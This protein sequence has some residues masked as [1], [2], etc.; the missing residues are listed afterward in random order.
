ME[1]CDEC[2]S[3][4]A[5]K[6]INGKVVMACPK[7]GAGKELSKGEQKHTLRFWGTH[8]NCLH[9]DGVALAVWVSFVYFSKSLSS[10]N[11]PCVEIPPC[12]KRSV[13]PLRF[14][15][16]RNQQVQVLQVNSRI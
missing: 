2:S 4:L 11:A 5:P 15:K 1:F 8:N 3:L 6:K 7:C 9:S 13:M 14:V 10:Q 16:V 12:V